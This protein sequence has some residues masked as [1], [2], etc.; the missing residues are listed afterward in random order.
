MDDSKVVRLVDSKGGMM[1]EQKAD[2]KVAKKVEL[3]ADLTVVE[4]VEWRAG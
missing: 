4:T 1:D 2:K 3:K